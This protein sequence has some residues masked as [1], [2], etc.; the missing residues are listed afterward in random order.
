MQLISAYSPTTYLKPCVVVSTLWSDEGIKETALIWVEALNQSHALEICYTKKEK[1]ITKCSE[2]V[3]IKSHQTPVE[4][5]K[6]HT[7]MSRVFHNG[8]SEESWEQGMKKYQELY[9]KHCPDSMKEK[10]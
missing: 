8:G 9:K 4:A 6:F 1:R 3:V 5:E 2:P 7:R 10:E